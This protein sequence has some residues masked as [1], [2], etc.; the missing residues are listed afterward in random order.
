MKALPGADGTLVRPP[1][2]SLCNVVIDL[3]VTS[4][5]DAVCEFCPREFMPDR[6]R[7]MSLEI[8]DRLAEELRRQRVLTVVLCGIGE[9]TL[10]PQLDQIVRALSGTDNRVEMTTHGGAR[11]DAGRFETLVAQGLSGFNFSLNAAAAETHRKVMRLKDFDQTVANLQEI[12]ELRQRAYPHVAV[13]VSFVVCNLNHHEV[14]NFVEFWRPKAP[15]TI[16]LHPVNNRNGLLSPEVRPAEMQMLARR[17]ADDA[18]VVVDL[19]GTFHE[20]DNLCKI[21][22]KMIFI[23]PDGEMRL[24]AMDYRRATSYGNLM[25]QSLAEMHHGKIRR[26]LQGEMNEFCRGCDFC[27]AGLRE[28]KVEVGG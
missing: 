4:V 28:H 18:L 25:Y 21:A 26:Y 9:S 20:Q 1:L 16:W 19:L 17:Y 24:C 11:L 6:K 10:H 22:K 13:H 27:P 8:V 14:G 2:E 5:C 7:F 15:S 3:E 12:L 23:S